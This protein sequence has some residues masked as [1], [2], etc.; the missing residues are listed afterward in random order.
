MRQTED[1]KAGRWRQDVTAAGFW[2]WG[3][4]IEIDL[5]SRSCARW[6]DG[7]APASCAAHCAPSD[8]SRPP[9]VCVRESTPPSPQ[10]RH[11]T[12]RRTRTTRAAVGVAGTGSGKMA[13]GRSWRRRRAAATSWS[14][15]DDGQGSMDD[16][17]RPREKSKLKPK[18]KLE[19][20]SHPTEAYIPR[21]QFPRK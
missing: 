9:S 17:R 10:R 16:G 7:A 3:K 1:Q 13:T 21:E 20:R 12:A 19:P 11:L 14:Q 8:D 2:W 6:R 5:L 18:P 4:S 15:D